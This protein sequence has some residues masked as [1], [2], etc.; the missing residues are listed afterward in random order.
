MPD[1]RLIQGGGG[2]TGDNWLANLEVGT[3]FACADKLNR[4]NFM[5]LNL[6]VIR[7]DGKIVRLWKVNHDKYFGDVLPE[8]FCNQFILVEVIKR[9]NEQEEEKDNG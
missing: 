7:K 9:P 6:E 2:T 5:V 1:L 4:S 3:V 8:R